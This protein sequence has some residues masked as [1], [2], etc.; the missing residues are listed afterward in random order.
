MS[1]RSQRASE[2]SKSLTLKDNGRTSGGGSENRRTPRLRSAGMPDRPRCSNLVSRRSITRT[3]SRD[4]RL[5]YVSWSISSSKACSARKNAAWSVRRRRPAAASRRRRGS[6]ASSSTTRS[7]K[8]GMTTQHARRPS[9]P[10]LPSEE[11]EEA[12]LT[13]NVDG[14]KPPAGRRER[15]GALV[16]HPL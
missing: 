5:Q 10:G 15:E 12:A 9:T 1:L 8:F 16:R 14:L 2:R 13:A 3:P 4:S 7:L 6:D 11:S